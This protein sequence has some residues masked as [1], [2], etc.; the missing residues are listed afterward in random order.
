MKVLISLFIGLLFGYSIYAQSITIGEKFS[1]DSKVLSEERHYNVYL[2]PSY[3]KNPE[4]SY[5]VLYVMDG[6]YNFHHITGVVEQMSLIGEKIPELIVVG[7]SDKGHKAYVKN[8]TPFDTI[9]NKDGQ[10][11]LFF[12]FIH[13]ELKPLINHKFRT[14]DYDILFGHSLGGLFTIQT[15]LNHPKAF[16]AYIAVSPSLWWD[17]YSL[18]DRVEGFYEK[19]ENLGVKLFLS[20]GDE[21][22]MGVYGFYNQLDIGNFADEYLKNTPLGLEYTFKVYPNENHNSVGLVSVKDAL[23]AFFGTYST[24]KNVELST[25][26]EYMLFFDTLDDNYKKLKFPNTFISKMVEVLKEEDI[27]QLVHTHPFIKHMVNHQLGLKYFKNKDNKQALQYL[28][29]LVIAQPKSPEYLVSLAKVYDTDHQKEKAS[30]T[31]KK[32]YMLAKTL[33]CRNWYLNELK[34]YIK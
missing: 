27:K 23:H 29:K 32:A 8:T 24:V 5:P 16:T 2:P 3:F 20:L 34:S 25:K 18:E 22:G 31:Y 9:S 1:L 11:E 21:K 33:K 15:L 26:E 13:Q 7:I 12:K 4:Y 17:N 6:D 30:E 14:I 28:N 19:H 10:A